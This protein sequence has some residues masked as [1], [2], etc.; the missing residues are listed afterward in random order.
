MPFEKGEKI[1]ILDVC[2]NWYKGRK[3]NGS[4]GMVP[5]NY[6]VPVVPVP[7][8]R[9]DKSKAE[10]GKMSE[11]DEEKHKVLL[12]SMPW[13][14]GQI[15]RAESNRL[16]TSQSNGTF[17][18]RNSQ[19]YP[20]DYTLSVSF[21]RKVQHYHI[22]RNAAGKITVGKK[23]YFDTLIN[24]VEHYQKNADELGCC[25]KHSTQ[26]DG[27]DIDFM[28]RQ[29]F[30]LFAKLEAASP[31]YIQICSKFRNDW[32]KGQ[33]PDVD[34]VFEVF[35]WKAEK[36]WKDYKATL[37]SKSSPTTVE[38]YYHGT[39]IKCDLVVTNSPCSHSDCGICGIS[40]KGFKKKLVGKNISKFKRFGNG[41]YLAP[42][43]SKS[44]D[45]TR[46]THIHR[47]MLLCD[48]LPG[49]KY[50]FT[51]NQTHLAAPPDGYDSVY[52][53]PGHSLNYPEIVLFEEASI[54]PRYVILYT[55]DGIEKIAK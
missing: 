13:F 19:T 15:S 43:S 5:S 54:L 24:L 10:S 14:H 1:V 48:V 8:A 25:L 53:K 31:E 46:G 16:L 44:H 40:W 51:T 37:A 23:M 21:E 33:C 32:A 52:G 28:Q 7:P 36:R 39:A 18:I 20:G 30:V 2:D 41:F 4:E 50:T 12:K 22:T 34:H 3:R 11:T 49:N 55:R 42:H 38:Q 29:T 26:K 45:Y 17:L 47:A 27:G 35:C 9:A 6:V